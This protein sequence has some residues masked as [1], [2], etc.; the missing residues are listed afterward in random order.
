MAQVTSTAETTVP[1]AP[2]AVLAA[3]ADYATV[4]PAVLPEQYTD[5]AVLAGGTGDGTVAT[6][7]LHATKKRVRHVEADVTTTAD[8][9]VEKDR[10]SSLVTTF[11]VSPA[12]AGSRVVATT[13]WDG[14]GGIGGFFERTFAPKGLSRIHG[15]LLTNLAQR[16]S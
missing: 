9:V 11:R 7:R 16:L 1:A 15:E 6:W 12:G 3:L 4:R 5:Y 14:A 13:T 8:A 10:N 2:D